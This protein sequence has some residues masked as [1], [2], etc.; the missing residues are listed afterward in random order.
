MS[1]AMSISALAKK[2]VVLVPLALAGLQ[3]AE[4]LKIRI[5]TRVAAEQ[6]DITAWL[7][8]YNKSKEAEKKERDD[9][10]ESWRKNKIIGQQHLN[11]VAAQASNNIR[12]PEAE[13]ELLSLR[14]NQ[15]LLRSMGCT[16]K[17]SKADK[18]R[19]ARLL[20]TLSGNQ[21]QSRQI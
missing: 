20:E 4:G 6:E 19:K 8:D 18:L 13:E 15:E 5:R 14:K 7:Y 3:G 1:G 10:E 12:N 21:Q 9:R 16:G 11:T 17:L 2:A